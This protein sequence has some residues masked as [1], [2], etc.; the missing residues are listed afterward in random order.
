MPSLKGKAVGNPL[1]SVVTPVYNGEQ[2]LRECIESVL[3]QTYSHW[4][5][6]IVNNC[7]TDRTLEIAQEYEAKDP[8]IRI[9]NNEAFVRVIA[10]FNI[11]FRQISPDSKYCKALAAD[12]WLFAEC[13][14]KMVRV[15]EEHAS[16]AIVA[17]Y[18]LL[19]TTVMSADVLPYYRT[20][21][22]GHEACRR[23]LLGGNFGAASLGLYRADLVRRRPSF[24]NESNLHADSEACFELLEHH[25][26]GFVHQVL[27]FRREREDSLTSLSD[28]I[29]TYL[30]NKLA[31]LLAYG[32]RYL[33]EA[34]QKRRLGELL[35]TYYGYLAR[36]V[37]ERRGQKFWAF[38]RSKLAE[39]GLPLSRA[40]LT[41][42]AA[43]F[44]LDLLLNPKNTAEQLVRRLVRG[45]PR[46]G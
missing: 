23:R 31:E 15:A 25:D 32:P 18:N 40:R 30:P 44:A 37:Y 28:S 11:A 7:S 21:M 19:G 16:V 14:E 17:A 33:S 39:L 12:D 27:T 26:F 42:H 22:P 1:V 8:R 6:T 5:Y 41:A 38:H 35:Q 13:L 45:R 29:N 34:E 4:D 3:A 2:Y 43:L 10:N 46:T 9:H 36:Q 20:L 24:Y